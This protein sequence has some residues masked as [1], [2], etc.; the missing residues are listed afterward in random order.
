ML[1]YTKQ[2]NFSDVPMTGQKYEFL[3]EIEKNF[4]RTVIFDIMN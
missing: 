2:K 4:T 3:K 1:M